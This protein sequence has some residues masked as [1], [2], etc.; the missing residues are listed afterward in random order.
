MGAIDRRT[1]FVRRVLLKYRLL[2]VA[3][4]YLQRATPPAV[5]SATADVP[6]VALADFAA[7]LREFVATARRRGSVPVLMTRPH[8]PSRDQMRDDPTWRRDVPRYA[9]ETL[10]VA[11]A[12]GVEVIDVERAFEGRP[13]LFADECHLTDAGHQALAEL[14]ATR[15]ARPL[16]LE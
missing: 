12:E 16:G 8:R 2:L 7:N 3:R 13:A 9:D 1:L 14:V 6:R 10:R 4:H 5:A 15:L 11:A